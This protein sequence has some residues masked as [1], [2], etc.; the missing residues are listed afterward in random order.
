MP[1]VWFPKPLGVGLEMPHRS[2]TPRL[3]PQQ[4]MV[5]VRGQRNLDGGQ[6]L[7]PKLQPKTWRS[8]WAFWPRPAR[9][10]PPPGANRMA[11][12]WTGS[13]A[14][15]NA[16]F[17]ST[18]TAPWPGPQPCHYRLVTEKR[19]GRPRPLPGT[20]PRATPASPHR[21]R[22][23][24]GLRA[25]GCRGQVQVGRSKRNTLSWRICEIAKKN[26]PESLLSKPPQAAGSGGLESRM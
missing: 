6:G 10:A 15:R 8:G 5:P 17:M 25:V 9:P 22:K 14:S 20:K 18:E 11:F 23:A 2:P 3:C 21:P 4:R 26:L 24:A 19:T 13:A 7:L 1:P 12:G 16:L